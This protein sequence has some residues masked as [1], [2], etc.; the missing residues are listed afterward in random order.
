MEGSARIAAV[1][2][3]AGL[4]LL[5]GGVALLGIGVSGHHDAA[6]VLGILAAT[7]GLVGLRVRAW[8][9]KEQVLRRVAV[10]LHVPPHD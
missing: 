5:V 7:L 1:S 10:D 3:I 9:R 4:L 8:I 6:S 2:G